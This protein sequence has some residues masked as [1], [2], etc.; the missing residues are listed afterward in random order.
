M[1]PEKLSALQ[2]VQFDI[3]EIKVDL[4]ADEK[5]LEMIAGK[6]ID[7]E[8]RMFFLVEQINRLEQQISL[9]TDSFEQ[10]TNDL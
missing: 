6:V 8:R 3:A 9:S 5:I 2:N 4:K 1:D 10:N 7:L